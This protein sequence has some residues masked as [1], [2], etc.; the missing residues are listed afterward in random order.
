MIENWDVRLNLAMINLHKEFFDAQGELKSKYSDYTA[1]PVC[2]SDKCQEYAVKD[3]FAYKKCS[4]CGMVY[5]S[6]RLNTAATLSFYNS[7]VN[8]IYNEKKFHGVPD[9]TSADDKI[10]YQNLQLIVKHIGEID[11][12][13]KPLKGKRV[14]E[15]GCAKGYFLKCAKELGAEVYGIELNAKNII[16]ARK[17]LGDNIYAQ[18]IFELN[19]PSESFDV[20]YT[21]DVIEHISEPM[22]FLKELS[23]VMKP[24]ALIFT[25]THNIDG[26]IHRFVKERHTCIFGF[27]HPVHWSPKTLSTALIE[28]GIQS[29]EVIFESLDFRIM[30]IINYFRQ[31]TFTTIFPWKAGKPLDFFLTLISI[32]FRIPGIRNLDKLLLP[33]LANYLAAGSTMKMI[34]FKN[35]TEKLDKK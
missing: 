24:G 12:T 19:L 7:K 34:A 6:P 23:R 14:L 16:I 18:D 13:E 8:E 20:I 25:D 9:G 29:K 26:L 35:Q 32:P 33:P 30:D 1:C 27:E 31:S 21:R 28:N 15:V 10:N 2:F 22:P 11:K 4:S 17:F 5:M 3:K